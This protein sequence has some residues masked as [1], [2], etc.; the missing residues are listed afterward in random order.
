MR[1]GGCKMA[2]VCQ[3]VV[4]Q[5]RNHLRKWGYGCENGILKA[6]G[7]SQNI[8]QLRNE[9]GGGGGAAKWHSCA[10]GVFRRGGHGVAKSFRSQG[11][12]SSQGLIS[13]HASWGCKIS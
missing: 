11:G 6:L 7:I 5:L 13:Q 2:L 1:R 12:F 8:S 3:E 10:K 4:S 9:G